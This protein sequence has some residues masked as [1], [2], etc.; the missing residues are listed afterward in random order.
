VT[1]IADALGVSAGNGAHAC[2][3]DTQGVAQCWGSN[4]NGQLGNGST[5]NGNQP[6]KVLSLDLTPVFY[7]AVSAGDQHSCGLTATG[8]V[9]CWGANDRGQLGVSGGDAHSSVV[10][11][12][13]SNAVAIAAGD[14]FTCSLI[15]DGTVRCW[16]DN[17]SKQLGDGGGETFST[18]PVTV[19]GLA[20]I[21]AI[22]A[23]ASHVCALTGAGTMLC[24]GANSRGQLGINSTVPQPFPTTVQGLNDGVA[25]SAGAFF[26]CAAQAGGTASCWGANDAGEL[27]VK[28]TVD[29]LT[30]TPVAASVFSL[31]TGGTTFL[32]LSGVVAIATGTS[33]LNPT[34]EHACALLATG[35]IKC[36]GDN[37]QGEIGDGTTTNRARPTLVNSFAANVDP[38]A[39]LRNGRVAEVTA[40]IDCED[41]ENAHITL[42]LDQGAARGTGHAHARCED[43]LVR[44][45]MSVAAEGPS[46]FEPGTA[47]ANVEATGTHWTRQVVLSISK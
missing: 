14:K 21:A 42:T 32:A 39:T 6:A 19:A 5:I 17:S 20:N 11:G 22:T 45:P 35:V 16:G 13:I 4:S 25:V 24:W 47:T 34:H 10:V 23:G 30:P 28:D 1:G 33:P 26:T 31:P 9:R 41:G 44:V 27:G 12:G 8:Q 2:A 15:V 43:R 40:L 3:V 46:G 18:T 37:S 38:A 29:H 36:W 7:I